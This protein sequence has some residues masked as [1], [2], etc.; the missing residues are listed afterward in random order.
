MPVIDDSVT[1]ACDITP[2]P[3]ISDQPPSTEAMPAVTVPA[4]GPPTSMQDVAAYA[5][6]ISPPAKR[7]AED[8]VADALPTPKKARKGTVDEALRTVLHVRAMYRN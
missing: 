2:V 6:N 1:R 8:P 7:S 4:T 3:V 5:F